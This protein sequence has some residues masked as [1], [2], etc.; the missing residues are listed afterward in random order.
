MTIKIEH[1]IKYKTEYYYGY[2][3]LW[4]ERKNE[5]RK[6]FPEGE[7]TVDFEGSRIPNRKVD[8]NYGHLNLYP[9]RD[10]INEGDCLIIER[11]GDIIRIYKKNNVGSVES[12]SI[13]LEHSPIRAR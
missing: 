1:T 4:G 13:N 2:L 7:F 8:W 9:I 3:S 10:K 12:P 11:D 5:Y 6:I